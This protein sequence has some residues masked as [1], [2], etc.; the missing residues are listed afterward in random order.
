MASSPGMEL[1]SL[2]AGL[3]SYTVHQSLSTL[4]RDHVL[5]EHWYVAQ[6][7]HKLDSR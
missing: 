6:D 5:P 3:F 1:F 4:S 7:W 2:H